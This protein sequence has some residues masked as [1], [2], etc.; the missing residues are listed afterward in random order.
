VEVTA[1]TPVITFRD[2]GEAAAFAR[3]LV[4]VIRLGYVARGAHPPLLL[5]EGAERLSSAVRGSDGGSG[6]TGR[7]AQVPGTSEPGGL[8]DP[9]ACR[10]PV[11]T[12]TEAARYAEVST[13]YLTRICRGGV[14]G[15]RTRKVKGQWSVDSRE[16]AA[17][18]EATRRKE[19][20]QKDA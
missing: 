6:Q 18:C 2:E 12:A 16:L 7:S 11:L 14:L 15:P 10:K 9:P 20:T 1:G 4:E 8:P 5:L 19:N 13:E 17:W 3:Q